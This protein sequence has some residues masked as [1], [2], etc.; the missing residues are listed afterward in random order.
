LKVFTSVNYLFENKV[1]LR[2]QFYKKAIV[3]GVFL[4]AIHLFKT[5]SSGKL[6]LFSLRKDF[7]CKENSIR[8]TNLKLS[9]ITT[10]AFL[11]SS[12][13]DFNND[14][15]RMV[16]NLAISVA[17]L[18]SIK[19][20]FTDDKGS[21]VSQEHIFY[22]FEDPDE[23]VLDDKKTLS[24]YLSNFKL[25]IKS[26]TEF[27]LEGFEKVFTQ[28]LSKN[29]KGYD[30]RLEEIRFFK[31]TYLLNHIYS[32]SEE[33]SKEISF[34]LLSEVDYFFLNKEK[35]G[36][37][38]SHLQSLKEVGALAYLDVLRKG[39]ERPEVAFERGSYNEKQATRL[40]R[41]FR[42]AGSLEEAKERIA[43]KTKEANETADKREIPLSFNPRR[44]LSLGKGFRVMEEVEK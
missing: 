14:N 3:L 1:F 37:I 33:L 16:K 29:E 42:I 18:V 30:P 20:I 39:T 38:F 44:D 9:T 15:L 10:L 5:I 13:Y 41:D 6:H 4:S 23:K 19:S 27:N 7:L 32:L 28:V 34:Y 22:L 2:N 31:I 8:I 17:M 25:S 11:T 26:I 35:N 12:F 21:S 24:N 43:K 36:D 40:L